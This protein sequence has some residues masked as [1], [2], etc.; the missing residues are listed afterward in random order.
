MNHGTETDRRIDQI[1]AELKRLEHL[2]RIVD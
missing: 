1:L 2:N